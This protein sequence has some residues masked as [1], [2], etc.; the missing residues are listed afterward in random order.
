MLVPKDIFTKGVPGVRY[1]GD[2]VR[3]SFR[4]YTRVLEIVPI[5]FK[6][7]IEVKVTK[8]NSLRNI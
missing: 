2:D 5:I 1:L 8:S 4:N 3:D 7:S 6:G